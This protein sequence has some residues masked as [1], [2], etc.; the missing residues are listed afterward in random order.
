M[1]RSPDPPLE[2]TPP[3]DECVT[4]YDRDHLK[5]YMRLLDAEN[6]GASVAEIAR[7]LL[8]IDPERE[9]ERAHLVHDSHLKR[10]RWMTEHGYRDLLI[11][12]LPSSS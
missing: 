10:A 9:P 5:L 3:S 6:S 8:G 1:N 12:G 4:V 11:K 2:D 7:F